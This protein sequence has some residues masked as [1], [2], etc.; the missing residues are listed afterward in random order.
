MCQQ[1]VAKIM[2]RYIH[3]TLI[4]LIASGRHCSIDSSHDDVLFRFHPESL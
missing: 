3:G 1:K 4:P 2:P